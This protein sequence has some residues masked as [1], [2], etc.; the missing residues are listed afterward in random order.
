MLTIEQYG[1]KLTRVQ[2]D[3]IELIRQWRNSEHVSSN[4]EYKKYISE[5]EQ[6][7]WFKSINNPLNY[8]FLIE[9]EKKKIGV[10]NVKNIQLNENYGEGGIFI[11]DKNYIDSFASTFSSL[12]LL[13]FT[14]SILLLTTKSR[15]KIFRSNK[16]AIAYN[17]LLGYELLP[18]QDDLDYQ[19]YELTADRYFKKTKKTNAIAAKISM[20]PELK[21]SG[22]VCDEN[23]EKINQLITFQLK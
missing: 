3:D 10:I 20:K 15:I 14:F 6:M 13:N 8:Y 17:K 21:F 22:S 11:G 2:S 18:G 7:K 5:E 4:M 16:N 1:I 9:F 19:T 23:H 12:C